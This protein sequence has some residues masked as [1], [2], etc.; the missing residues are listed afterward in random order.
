MKILGLSVAV[1]CAAGVGACG[2]ITRGT[3]EKMAFLSEPSGAAMTTTKGYACPATPCSLDVERSDEF[4]VTFVKPGYRPAMVPVRTKVAGAGAAGMAGNLLAGGLI[5]VGVDAYTGAAM[6]HT[7][8][9]VSAT[10]VPDA[11]PSAERV[12]RRRGQ[13]GV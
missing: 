6:D 5:G 8:N 3:T 13:P 10:L 2:S 9:P 1:L 12:R 11:L 7:P 4:D